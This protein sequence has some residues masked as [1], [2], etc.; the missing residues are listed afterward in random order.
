MGIQPTAGFD[1]SARAQK[2]GVEQGVNVRE[3]E[4]EF[5]R[6]SFRNFLV[7]MDGMVAENCAPVA[8]TQHCEHRERGPSRELN[9][10]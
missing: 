1:C 10:K 2:N 3:A 4:V 7:F 6:M 9:A 8:L 5:R